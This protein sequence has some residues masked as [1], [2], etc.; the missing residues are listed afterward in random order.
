MNRILKFVGFMDMINEATI[1]GGTKF[2]LSRPGRDLSINK[3]TKSKY[4]TTVN[5]EFYNI[6]FDPTDEIPDNDDLVLF[7]GS[8]VDRYLK[9]QYKTTFN[10]YQF[11]DVLNKLDIDDLV[12]FKLVSDD[13]DKNLKWV[14]GQ[15]G[16]KTNL[17]RHFDKTSTSKRGTHF[18]ETAFLITL[19]IIGWE[20]FGVK[21]N[22]SS[23]KGEIGM[24]FEED[25][26]RKCY[27]DDD[28]YDTLSKIYGEF[29]L[30]NK[31]MEAMRAQCRL[32]LEDINNKGRLGELKSVV[33][34]SSDMIINQV[35]LGL[36]KE[37]IQN[38][39]DI[40]K[41]IKDGTYIDILPDTTSLAKWNP[42][43]IWLVFDENY[44]TNVELYPEDIEEM[45]DELNE[46]ISDYEGIVGVSLKQS[47]KDVKRIEVN[48]SLSGFINTYDGFRISND[49]KTAEI[50]FKYKKDKDSP[51]SE[52][53]GLDVRTFTSDKN[54]PISIELK[55]KKGAGYV[56]GKAGS[57]MNYFLPT[58]KIELKNKIRKANT[59]SEL[60]EILK[61]YEPINDTLK[62]ILE[63]D[64]EGNGDKTQE[65]NSRIQ[66]VIFLDWLDS[67]E[68]RDNVIDKI[69][70]F[71]K[72][73]MD[74]SAPHIVLK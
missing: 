63:N 11:K 68:D 2:E 54:A 13:V 20:E 55:G 21:L 69:V 3:L 71:A 31:V 72:S 38:R 12:I 61:D 34:N 44:L 48:K 30:N 74:W 36:I 70:K 66:S 17:L 65:E 45:N 60:R 40:I 18:R 6:L 59:K 62:E 29:I 49:K 37:E 73:E 35:A 16:S 25:N 9:T 42:S 7:I 52:G 56:S 1:V 43:D 24:S 64:L 8:L 50:D 53:S 15:S 58:D 5:P 22:I 23:N 57:M 28:K 47:L 14:V 51:E 67:N 4:I 41:G 10:V 27:I 32:L 33:K 39:K 26:V 46:F 19:A